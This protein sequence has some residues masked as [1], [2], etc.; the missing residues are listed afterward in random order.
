MADKNATGEK[1]EAP[2]PKRKKEARK[3]GQVARTPEFGGWAS[4]LVVA[5]L[6]PV[7]VPR[8]M[9]RLTEMT[10]SSLRRSTEV[11]A[12]EA[13][14]LVGQGLQHAL[15]VLVL[16]GAIVLLVAVAAAL[17]QGGFYVASKAVKPSLKKLDPLQGLKRVFG[18]HAAWE[19]VKVLAKASVLSLVVWFIAK[20]SMDTV[21]QLRTTT[22]VIAGTGDMSLRLLRTVALAA[23]VLAAADYAVMRRRTLK[24][25]R[26]SKHDVKQE[27]KQSEGDPMLKGARRSRQIAMSRNRM[28]A[29][30]ADAD[31]VLVNPTHVAVALR[32]EQDAGAPKVVARGAGIVAARIRERAADHDVP[33][34]RD[35]PLARALY[36]STEVGM[37]VPAELFVAVAQVLAFV[38]SRR[39]RGARGGTH[40]TP[41]PRAAVTDLPEVADAARRRRRTPGA[42]PPRPRPGAHRA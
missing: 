9:A 3:E 42:A 24:Q 33:M 28:M 32:Y 4:V 10:V 14:L 16:L 41:R 8:E 34:V 19:G 2:T 7:L 1:T 20:G 21:G 37:E 29:S 40:D 36:R 13:L 25:T 12:E 31:V 22:D 18:P 6:A 17:S 27:N 26:M 35:V 30:V 23:L 11:S 15:V 38:I 5:L 39:Q